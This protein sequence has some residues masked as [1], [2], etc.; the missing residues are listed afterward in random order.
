MTKT[1][2]PKC[3]GEGDL[4][5]RIMDMTK[6]PPYETGIFPPCDECDGSG[7]IKDE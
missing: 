7:E 5:A 4:P 3:K 1:T 6:N 2:C